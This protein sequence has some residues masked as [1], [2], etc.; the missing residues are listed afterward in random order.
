MQVGIVKQ[1]A[2]Y[3]QQVT[4]ARCT[5]MCLLAI[6]AGTGGCFTHILL[7]PLIAAE[8]NTLIAI[9]AAVSLAILGFLRQRL[10]K[11]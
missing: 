7:Q 9:Q 2:E 6:H 5:T 4:M 10:T 3:D 1:A 11:F 8:S